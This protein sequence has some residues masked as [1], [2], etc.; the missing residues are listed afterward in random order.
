LFAIFTAGFVYSYLYEPNNLKVEHWIVYLPGKPPAIRLIN[1][2]DIQTCYFGR[3][4]K[5]LIEILKNYDADVIALTGDYCDNQKEDAPHSTDSLA[6]IL[7]SLKAK[8]YMLAIRGNIEGN[9]EAFIDFFSDF[10]V[11]TLCDQSVILEKDNRKLQIIGMDYTGFQNRWKNQ[12]KMTADCSLPT[13]ILAHV[14]DIGLVRNPCPN[15]FMISGHTHGGQIRVP[16][17]GTFAS[18]TL[19]ERKK[20][21]GMFKIINDGTLLYIS[22]GVGLENWYAPKARTLCPPEITIIDIVSKENISSPTADPVNNNYT[23]R[24]VSPVFMQKKSVNLL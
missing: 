10:G 2:S 11:T 7:Q 13:I 16:I 9:K 6:K 19:I 5:K 18:A 17:I 22:R 21:Y 20:P 15:S 23:I 1:L 14:A 24:E 12:A 4:E 3:R 8:Y